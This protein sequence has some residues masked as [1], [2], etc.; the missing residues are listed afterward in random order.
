MSY[1]TFGNIP[2]LKEH[3]VEQFSIVKMTYYASSW[4]ITASS[5]SVAPG[6]GSGVLSA[7]ILYQIIRTNSNTN[8]DDHTLSTILQAFS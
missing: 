8:P 2:K 5:S 1:G 3:P 7:I 4:R 6:G